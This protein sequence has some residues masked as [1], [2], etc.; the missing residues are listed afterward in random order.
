MQTRYLD[1]MEQALSAYSL[2]DIDRYFTDVRESGLTEH[3]F[4]RLVAN[5]GRM[6]ARGR[7]R[8]L[9]DRFTA[10][11]D[12]VCDRIS[13]DRAANDFAVSELVECVT[14]LE[15]SGECD[16][17]A[18]ARWRGALSRTP[19][20]N[21]AATSAEQVVHNWALFAA[22][23]EFMRMRS[24]LCPLDLDAIDMQLE[25]QVRHLNA[26]GMY[27]DPGCPMVYDLV[28]RMLF[29]L[30]LFYGYNGRHRD[31]IDDALRRAG[32]LTLAMQSVTGEIPYGGRSNQFYH[33]EACLCAVLEFEARR[34]AG[35]G[36]EARA[37]Q[38]KRGAV[39]ALA[40]IERGME[41]PPLRHVKNR[42]PRESC[43]GCEDYAYFDKY[44]ITTAS[45]LNWAMALSDPHIA[46]A[47][48]P[49]TAPA[50]F[51]LAEE[52]HRVFL[53]SGDYFAELD[54][55]A[56][57]RYDASGLGRVHLRGAKSESCLSCPGTASGKL[58]IAADRQDD[59]AIAPGLILDD[60]TF[61]A[62]Q[63]EYR[64]LALSTDETT[65]SATFACTV[66]DRAVRFT[67]AVSPDG[68]TVTAESEG[69][70]AVMLPIIAT[71]GETKSIVIPGVDNLLVLYRGNICK[72]RTDGV[73]WEMDKVAG[74]RNGYY[75]LFG[76]TGEGAVTVRIAMQCAMEMD[77]ADMAFLDLFDGNMNE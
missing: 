72:Y 4:A 71:N 35:E 28:P 25:T 29:S 75:N 38:F 50:A 17:E 26:D 77:A 68:V 74:N 39:D 70:V 66:K 1:A 40:S 64:L 12:F 46:P 11:M 53:R 15:A 67:V 43:Y 52:F 54:T 41:V 37:A 32:E 60:D 56:D 23:G 16:A 10:M 44:M 36:D 73:I 5:I 21:R 42:F 22:F 34:Y 55:A 47:A 63:G 51:A 14:T 13:R 19:I 18:I 59:F 61:F 3:G 62:T 33:N 76:A 27:R 31:R 6:L 7:R 30:L 24:G 69:E 49:M 20:Y 9:H 2:A 58:H 8:D 48:E 57:P 45:F 65:A